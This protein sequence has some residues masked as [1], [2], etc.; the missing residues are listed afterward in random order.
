M[1]KTTSIKDTQSVPALHDTSP[2]F[3]VGVQRSGTTML[4]L[5][6]NQ[7]PHLA[8]PFESGF[9]AEFYRKIDR[10]GDLHDTGNR[11]RL[12][13]DI[14]GDDWVVRGKLI[15]DVTTIAKYPASDYAEI[16][17]AI[18][19]DYARRKGKPRWGDKTPGY[20][21][22][23]DTL[24]KVFPGC[25]FIHLVRDGRDVALS[26]RRIAWG[27]SSIPRM[28]HEWRWKTLLAHKM[29]NLLG[30]HFL[31]VR[32]EDL[33]L[34]TEATLR[35]ICAFLGESYDARMLDYH[36]KGVKADELPSDSIRWHRMSVRAPDPKKVFEWKTAMSEADQII[37]E[38]IA[39]DA[40]SAFGYECRGRTPT[41]KSRLR[42]LHYM[43][44]RRW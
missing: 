10:Y 7:H 5:M 24:W 12:L 28:A 42:K 27:T 3:I 39:G 16:V 14:A 4:R 8:I 22:E 36:V 11:N 40:L 26:L 38:E 41:L 15:D 23:I 20:V 37:F 43:L 2:F 6:L 1:N 34:D 30:D 25:K 13:S 31:E 17:A 9:I 44:I 21:D 19:Q 18:F 32:Y 35:T 33:V 29:G